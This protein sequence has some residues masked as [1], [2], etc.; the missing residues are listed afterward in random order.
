MVTS[1]FNSE[2][3][4]S[5]FRTLRVVYGMVQRLA[6]S[7]DTGRGKTRGS[8]FRI[9]AS[10]IIPPRENRPLR[11]RMSGFPGDE[12]HGLSIE[13]GRLTKPRLLQPPPFSSTE[14]KLATPCYLGRDASLNGTATVSGTCPHL[15]I[16]HTETHDSTRKGEN[17]GRQQRSHS[18]LTATLGP[19]YP[20]RPYPG[21]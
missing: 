11:N 17:I 10:W 5:S 19:A 15:R 3:I 12:C 13:D 4:P 14:P 9:G 6:S 7:H 18:R 16:Y 8:L 2:R 20:S 1:S 21:S